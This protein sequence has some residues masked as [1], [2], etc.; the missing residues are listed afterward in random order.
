M[1]YHQVEDIIEDAIHVVAKANITIR[2]RRDLIYK[3]RD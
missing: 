2:E 3:L 1:S